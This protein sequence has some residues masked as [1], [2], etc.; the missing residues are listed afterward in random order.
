VGEEYRLLLPEEA[1]G[2][3]KNVAQFYEWRGWITGGG[4]AAM[5]SYRVPLETPLPDGTVLTSNECCWAEDANQQELAAC[6]TKVLEL[7]RLLGQEREEF[8]KLASH[9][10]THCTCMETY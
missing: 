2:R 4:G 9:H 5:N 8:R 3:Y 1:D 7:E 6:R 10:N